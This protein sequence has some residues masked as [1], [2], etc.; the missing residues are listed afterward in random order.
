MKNKVFLF[1]AIFVL[2]LTFSLPFVACKAGKKEE[3]V[4][5][6]KLV[7]DTRTAYQEETVDN[8]EKYGKEAYLVITGK[9]YGY[10]V[11]KDNYSSVF[12]RE[13]KLEY[14][15]NDEGNISLISFI[16]G[17]GKNAHTF[18]VDAQKRVAL[19]SRWPSATKHIDAYDIQ[20]NKV[21]K[22]TDLS[23]V[24]NIYSNLPVFGYDLYDYNGLYCAEITNELQKNY[25]EYIYKYYDVDSANCKATLYYALKSDEKPVVVTDLAVTF[26]RNEETDKPVAISIGEIKYTFV[27]AT[28]TRPVK[29][30]VDGEEVDVNEELYNYNYLELLPSEYDA[31][32]QNLIT[33]Y[34]NSLQNTNK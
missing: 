24:K 21:D 32:F 2:S 26:E 31:Y 25:S 6:Y 1:I 13:V 29:V 33:E 14:T 11:Y 22:A 9:T 18:N 15:Y 27:Y 23:Y 4:G 20:Y 7:T 28:P 8:I 34:K 5:T 30:T 10:Y 17:E 3:V 19:I 16:T 12:A